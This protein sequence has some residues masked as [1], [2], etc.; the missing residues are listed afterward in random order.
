MARIITDRKI[1][2][3]VY[4]TTY[5]AYS[6]N[7]EVSGDKS[8]LSSEQVKTSIRFVNTRRNN[9]EFTSAAKSGKLLKQILFG[10]PAD[11]TDNRL[12]PHLLSIMI[13]MLREDST[14][15]WGQRM[16]VNGNFVHLV[17]FDYNRNAPLSE[18]MQAPYTTVLDRVAGTMTNNIGS[19][20]PTEGLVPPAGLAST[21][22]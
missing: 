15:T 13:K 12:I 2:G 7:R 17:D 9:S 10:V 20:T 5:K 16:P 19:F 22:N 1:R 3:T 4:N 21:A 8:I 18:V 14:N 6:G 11:H